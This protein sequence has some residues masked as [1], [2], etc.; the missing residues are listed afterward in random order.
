MMTDYG[1]MRSEGNFKLATMLAY[2]ELKLLEKISFPIN[3]FQL[4][5]EREDIVILSYTEFQKKMR[6]SFDEVVIMA[7]SYDGCTSYDPR[8]KRFI[9]L[10]NDTIK[11]AGQVAFTIAHEFGHYKLCHLKKSGKNSMSRNNIYLNDNPTFEAEANA[12]AR[13]LLMPSFLVKFMP[14]EDID[15]MQNFFL[16]SKSFATYSLA[17]VNRTSRLYS[18]MLLET[19]TFLK[20]EMRI[21]EQAIA[22]KIYITQ[23]YMT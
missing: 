19:P 20:K 14:D 3:P 1:V 21:F 7:E 10:Y 15:Y 6:I 2:G 12:F 9:V 18:N 13:E 8:T 4:F 23:N 16:A 11:N 22:K 5:N 17:H